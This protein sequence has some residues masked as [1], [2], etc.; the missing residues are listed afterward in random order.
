M[1]GGVMS[2]V[3][4]VMILA[5]AGSGKTYALTNRYVRLLAHGALPE[6]I[7][8]LTFTRKAA[9]E[10]FDEILKKLAGAAGDEAKARRLANEI[11]MPELRAGDFL[12]LLR[13]VTESMHRLN[14]GTL[15]SFFARV[16]RAFPLELGL[17][18]D[19]EVLQ[20]HAARWER[21]RVLRRMFAHAR[22][23]AARQDFIEAFKRA[24]FGTEEKRLGTRLD[25]FLD[26]HAEVYLA[27]PDA[28]VWGSAARIWPQGN[29]WLL[30]ADPRKRAAAAEELKRAL[31]WPLLSDKQRARWD[32][33]LAGLADWTPGAPLPKAVAYVMENAFKAWPALADI[34]IER[35]KVSL[36]PAASSA[37][38]ALVSG[39]AGAELARRLEMT[40]G[41]AAVL[42]SY[43]EVYDSMVRRSG[44]LTFGDVQRLLRPGTPDGAR[45][46]TRE[47]ADEA[48]LFIDWR[49]DAQIDHWLLDEFQD[50]SF[51]QWSV[52]QNLI[53]EAVQD[54]TQARSFFY[55]G[56]VKQA[57]FAWREGDS[58]L[59]REIFDHY[60][61][62]I[63]GAIAEQRLD[64]SWR[65]GPAVIAM[66]NRVLGDG[67]ALGRL[68]PEKAV[69]RWMKEWRDHTSAQP[70]LE[71]YSALRRV[72]DRAGRFAETL[73]VIVETGALKRGLTVAVLV[74]KNSTAAELAD[75]LRREGG[76]PAIAESDLHVGRDNPLA[77]ALLALF[78]VAA[79]PGDRAAWQHVHMTPLREVLRQEQCMEVNALTVRLLGEIHAHGFARTMEA[80]VHRLNPALA[81]DDEFSRERG[82][83][84]T[85]AARL[86]DE[87]G[88]LDVAEFVHFAERHTVRDA[89]ATG[90]VRVMTV[91]KAKGLGFDLV[92]LPDLEGTR[93][94]ARRRGLAVERARDRTVE[95]VYDL[96]PELFFAQDEVLASHVAAAEAEACYE[97]LALLYVAMTRAK[98]AM[99]VV[100]EPVGTSQSHNFPRLLQDTLGEQWSAGDE[101]WFKVVATAKP[102]SRPAEKLAA[103]KAERIARR[104]A[105]TPSDMKEGDVTGERLFA[106]EEGDGAVHFGRAVHGLL[107]QVDWVDAGP[108]GRFAT[109]WRKE[110]VAGMEALAC[111][112]AP[113]LA[114]IWSRP[115][116]PRAEVWRERAFETVIEGVWVTGI[117]DRVVVSLDENGRS[118]SATIYDFKTDLVSEARLSE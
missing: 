45:L 67:A 59:F 23:G 75:Y 82:R 96:P 5:S 19:F 25:A 36:P 97:E 49:L 94:A 46:L 60:N 28:M 104:L 63:P 24:T 86:F 17:G 26:E 102:E 117:F 70:K 81:S 77:C 62:A 42:R 18:G 114:D 21:Q 8:A 108:S 15:D 54:P 2:G 98:R 55:V 64:R 22:E 116:S 1:E 38:R 57:I 78:W 100:T 34:I 105:H 106:L 51:G 92:V 50:T 84:L 83:Q 91:H 88:S 66:V 27:A 72:K 3:G 101:Q 13:R 10:F 14:L 74:Q 47:A 85:E 35:K 111:L 103:I 73:R 9:G 89:D 115:A 33:F 65:S 61:S 90:V 39:I 11:E 4:H 93:L 6:R 32:D 68:F 16:V 58:R 71:G 118:L 29:A 112:C 30:G 43:E 41:V 48:R 80:W 20:E 12:R 56:D 99:Y 79:H 76:L 40:Q 113:E 110:G 53:D 95:W 52:L 7:A 109:E 69:S 107:A 87:A 44:R 31:P 37:L